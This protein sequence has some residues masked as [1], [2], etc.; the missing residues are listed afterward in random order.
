MKFGL[1]EMLMVVVVI[2]LII[3]VSVFF[4]AGSKKENEA[5][6]A[7]KPRNAVEARDQEILRKRRSGFKFSGTVFI[8]IGILLILGAPG[9]IKAVVWSYLGGAVI[10]LLGLA[11]FFISKRS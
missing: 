10:I 2:G 1:F 4:P 7:R 8:I 11:A 5:L 3:A 6:L 9:L